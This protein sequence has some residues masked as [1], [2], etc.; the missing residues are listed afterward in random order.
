M[1]SRQI[2]KIK[3]LRKQEIRKG[4]R[5][6]RTAKDVD[7]VLLYAFPLLKDTYQALAAEYS[8]ADQW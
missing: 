1:E 6:H 8:V 5:T 4:Y 3:K 7:L 2:K